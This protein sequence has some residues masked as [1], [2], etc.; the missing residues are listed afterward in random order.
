LRAGLRYDRDGFSDESLVSPRFAANWRVDS[1]LRVSASAGVFHQSPRFL[2]R[3]AHPENFGIKN[4]RVT[5]ASVGIQ[6]FF[7]RDWSLLVEPY[8]QRLSRLVVEQEDTSGRVGNDGTGTN[9]GLDVVLS[10]RFARGWSANVV[11]AYNRARINNN[12]GSG[13]QDADFNRKHFFSMGGSWQI[14]ER[15]SLSG[16]WKWAAGRP[17]DDFTIHSDVLGPGQPLRYSKELTRPNALRLDKLHAL[18]VRVDYRRN[19]GP[20]DLVGFLDVLNVYGGPSGGSREFDPR[21]GVNVADEGEALPIIG[22]ILER[23]W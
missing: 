5:H 1:G 12:D 11:Y 21:R 22:L 4:E 2:V 10:R 18:N 14:N 3:A 15:W 23:S 13:E 9:L 6:Q 8:H 7:G 19:L 17:T 16:R 20:V